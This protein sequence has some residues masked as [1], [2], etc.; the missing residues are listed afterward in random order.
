[1]NNEYYLGIDIGGT[2]CA[3]IAGTEEMEILKKTGFP[4]ETSKGPSHAINLLL[5]SASEIIN[6]LGADR[7]KAIGIS[8]GGPLDSI[9]GIVQSPPNLPGWDDIPYCRI[10]LKRS[11]MFLFIYRMM[12]MPVHLLNGNSAQEKVPRIWYS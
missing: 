8:C 9:K 3:V 6:N 11:S 5:S 12:Q 7:L 2:K 1:M 4:T 10:C